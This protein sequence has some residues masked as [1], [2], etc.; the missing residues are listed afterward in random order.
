MLLAELTLQ[1]PLLRI[2]DHLRA[3]ELPL[4]CE[5]HLHHKQNDVDYQHDGREDSD[6]CGLRGTVVTEIRDHKASQ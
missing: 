5:G 1:L 3:F 6:G 4:D 2:V